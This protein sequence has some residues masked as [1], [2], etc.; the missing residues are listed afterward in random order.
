MWNP[1]AKFKAWR[2]AKK[3]QKNNKEFRSFSDNPNFDETSSVDQKLQNVINE[4][5]PLRTDEASNGNDFDQNDQN[6]ESNNVNPS[7]KFEIDMDQLESTGIEEAKVEELPIEM[8]EQK[9]FSH[10][11]FVIDPNQSP[12]NET[13]TWTKPGFEEL[14][15]LI[16]PQAKVQTFI[17]ELS[18]AL[19]L[20]ETSFVPEE[21]QSVLDSLEIDNVET[22]T[23]TIAKKTTNLKKPTAKKVTTG[24]KKTPVKKVA[25]K[26][27]TTKKT[28]T[29]T[30]AKKPAIKKS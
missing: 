25:T 9:T 2:A 8:L 13:K 10:Q 24:A 14:E 5:I 28:S 18:S 11:P 1:I 17:K 20:D 23:T 16:E 27:S 6:Q 15:E 19:E 21:N 12:N 30:G 29:T 3:A 4:Q 26:T 22:K 7:L